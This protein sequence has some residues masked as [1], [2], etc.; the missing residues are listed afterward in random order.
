MVYNIRERTSFW[1]DI[2]G[3]IM[4]L[5]KN[6][7]NIRRTDYNGEIS[8]N[9]DDNI[10]KWTYSNQCEKVMAKNWKMVNK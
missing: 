5:S 8:H 10:G 9:N 4:K 6:D 2:G 7:C 1:E 3:V